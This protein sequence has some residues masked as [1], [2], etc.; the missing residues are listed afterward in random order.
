MKLPVLYNQ[1]GLNQICLSVLNSE[2]R[3]PKQL[4]TK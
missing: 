1:L 2:M 3:H 4:L